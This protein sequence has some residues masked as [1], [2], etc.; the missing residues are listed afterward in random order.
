M[1]D[2]C[3]GRIFAA[4]LDLV[5]WVKMKACL[6]GI[7]AIIFY[8]PVLFEQIAGGATGSLL[9]TVVV[10]CGEPM[11]SLLIALNEAVSCS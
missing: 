8:A 1:P 11:V 9:S 2:V 5:H 3:S 4:S 7:N 10:D 6:Q